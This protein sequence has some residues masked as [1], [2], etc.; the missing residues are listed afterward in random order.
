LISTEFGRVDFLLVS[1]VGPSQNSMA[2]VLKLE[3]ER[4][5]AM[6]ELGFMT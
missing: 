5:M 3:T 2:A 6:M 1:F 4:M